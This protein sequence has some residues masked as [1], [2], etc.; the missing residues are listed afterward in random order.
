MQVIL[1][2]PTGNQNVRAILTSLFKKGMLAEFNTTIAVNP[3]SPYIK[4]L[5]PS[6][7]AQWLRRTY[8][9][10]SNFINN[11]PLLELCRMLLPKIGFS[12]VVEHEKGLASIDSIYRN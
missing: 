7:R 12:R 4:R 3:S 1:S 5:P 2:H 6:T 11:Y 9:I 8:P 10:P